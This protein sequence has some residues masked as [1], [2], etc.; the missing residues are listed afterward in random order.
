MMAPSAKGQVTR[1][2]PSPVCL[3]LRPLRRAALRSAR[4]SPAMGTR[5]ALSGPPRLLTPLRRALSPPLPRFARRSTSARLRTLSRQA[6]RS[7]RIPTEGATTSTTCTS[8]PRGSGPRRA[9]RGR[10][11]RAPTTA[12]TPTRSTRHRARPPRL[13][14]RRRPSARASTPAWPT[15]T[16]ARPRATR[17]PPRSARWQPLTRGWASRSRRPIERWRTSTRCGIACGSSAARRPRSRALQTRLP[18]LASTTRIVS[19]RSRKL[20]QGNAPR[21]SKRSSA[22]RKWCMTQWLQQVKRAKGRQSDLRYL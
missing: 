7:G 4:L 16:S 21:R 5:A 3:Q 8:S 14:P 19:R 6:G 15:T 12:A 13:P 11:E 20:E 17:W 2:R 18:K 10:A 1:S 9:T 22:S